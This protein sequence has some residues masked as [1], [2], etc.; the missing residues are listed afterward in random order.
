MLM[1]CVF[2]LR[3]VEGMSTCSLVGWLAAWPVGLVDWLAAWIVGLVG[4]LLGWFNWLDVC[5]VG[6]IGWLW[7]RT[8]PSLHHVL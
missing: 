5:F 2:S 3:T 4:R 8:R 1:G 6:W 7:L